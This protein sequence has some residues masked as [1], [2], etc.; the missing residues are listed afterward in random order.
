MRT[1]IISGSARKNG[2]T[3]KVISELLTISNWDHI[4]LSDFNISHFD[5]DHRN[6]D[7]DFITLIKNVVANYDVIILATP[8]Y[9]YSMSGI[10]KVFF[11][12]LTDLLK[13]EKDTGK[14]MRGKYMAAL[15][16]SNGNNLGEQFWL[17][18]QKS[19][20]YLGMHWIT[21]LHTYQDVNAQKELINFKNEIETF[22]L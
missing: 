13:I 4:V 8:V 16:S 18:F 2:D 6:K 10:M 3:N 11:D 14:Q 7:D 15:T 9:W 21:G 1:V 19:A 20:D 22:I 5:Y 17:P 12:R